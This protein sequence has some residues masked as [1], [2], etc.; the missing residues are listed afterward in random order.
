MHARLMV[1]FVLRL[2]LLIWRAARGGNPL[3]NVVAP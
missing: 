2:P 3:K 1:S